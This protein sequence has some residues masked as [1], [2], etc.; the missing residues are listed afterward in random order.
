M[1]LPALDTLRG[2]SER[3]GRTRAQPARVKRSASAL[4][5]TPTERWEMESCGAIEIHQDRTK[6]L[7]CHLLPC[8]RVATPPFTQPCVTRV[9]V[10]QG[11][12]THVTG[13]KISGYWARMQLH[14]TTNNTMVKNCI[15]R[16]TTT[17][18]TL[19]KHTHSA[20]SASAPLRPG[21][22]SPAGAAEAAAVRGP[23][24]LARRSSRRGRLEE[25]CGVRGREELGRAVVRA[26]RK[27]RAGSISCWSDG[28]ASCASRAGGAG[29]APTSPCPVCAEVEAVP[30]RSSTSAPSGMSAAMA[31]AARG[32]ARLEHL[33]IA[34]RRERVR[35]V[36]QGAVRRRVRVRVAVDEDAVAVVVAV[37]VR[38]DA[39]GR[40]R[41][42]VGLGQR[43]GRHER[44][45]GAERR[46]EARGRRA[47]ARAAPVLAED[48]E[49][50]AG[51]ARVGAEEERARGEPRAQDRREVVDGPGPERARAREPHERCAGG[52]RG[53]CRR[54]PCASAGAG[55]GRA[56]G[57]GRHFR[58]GARLTESAGML[59][60]VVA[61]D[62]DFMICARV[63]T[64]Q[65]KEI[66]RDA[67]H[68]ARKAGEA[69]LNRPWRCRCRT[70]GE[71]KNGGREETAGRRRA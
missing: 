66:V 11:C 69:R 9:L 45:G 6:W 31:S 3:L 2:P 16:S 63:R 19:H 10:T 12:V 47:R 50:G 1:P 54:R 41:A 58:V 13:P 43:L 7:Y 35:G 49:G 46:A 34:Q 71:R 64:S 60:S 70:A 57:Q 30:S 24:V 32:H 29:P 15:Q 68:R 61:V 65:R 5:A 56:Q 44:D 52:G 17:T 21:A 28:D 42:R 14:T 37:A 59:V 8:S 25:C 18:K 22:R 48:G 23:Q 38:R 53:A 36:E 39:H 20:G 51:R 26:A 4:S 27:R 67:H 40:P 55:A 62:A 33:H